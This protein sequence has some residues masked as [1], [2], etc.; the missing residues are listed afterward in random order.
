M[1][2]DAL[3]LRFCIPKGGGITPMCMKS[4]RA[5]SVK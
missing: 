3:S 5:F 2:K 4:L 1:V